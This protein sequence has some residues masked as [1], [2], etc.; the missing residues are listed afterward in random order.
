MHKVTVIIPT[1]SD[2]K[3]MNLRIC[4]LYDWQD[5]PN[6][7]LCLETGPGTVGAKRNSLCR[8]AP[9]D[10]IL[11]MDSDDLY[12]ADWITRSVE[13]LISSKA[14]I[15]GLS[16]GYFHNIQTG[17]VHLYTAPPGQLYLM[18]A[19]LC[20][21]R[22]TW[23]RKPFKDLQKGEDTDFISNNGRLHCHG[24]KD[25]F[26]ATI[27]GANTCSHVALPLMKK[28]RPED[29]ASVINHFYA[30]PTG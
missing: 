10:I 6:K 21:W 13:A 15:V 19:T 27:H 17:N 12:A 23:E 8:D 14:D 25:G 24:Y 3:E 4:Q 20:Y 22:K 1:T 2:R 9:G 30:S 18:G 16:T 28:L 7:S 5:Y 11:H 29:A 26:M